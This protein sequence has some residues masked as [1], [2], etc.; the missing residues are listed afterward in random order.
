M[1]DE[2]QID[3]YRRNGFLVIDRLVEEETVQLR[4][5]AYDDVLETA[6]VAETML[7]GITRQVMMPSMRHPVFADNPALVAA[8]ALAAP[9]L[10][11]PTFSF[12][13]LIDKPPG[14][15]HTTPW[16]QDMSYAAT[17]FAPPGATIMHETIQFWL[18]LDDADI[19]NGCMHF[20]AGYH[21]QPLLEHYVASGQPQDSSRLLAIVDPDRQLDLEA[22]IPGPIAA[23]GVTM[24]SYGTPHFTPVNRTN[25]RP[26]RAYIFN[27]STRERAERVVADAERMLA[28][29]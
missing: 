12:D 28:S 29:S 19:D 13:M 18:A 4:R 24:H 1:L 21:T 7:G 10:D 3:L 6:P 27:F 16:H 20:L 23:G 14:H 2:T 11:E 5:D 8:R 15:P 22:V 25:D 17:P 26:R 9:L